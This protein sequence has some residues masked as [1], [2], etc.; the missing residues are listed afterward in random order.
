MHRMVNAEFVST[1][2][3]SQL[4]NGFIE[5][6][7]GN[8]YD[9]CIIICNYIPVKFAE[10]WTYSRP[11]PMERA[12]RETVTVTLYGQGLMDNVS[13]KCFNP[14]KMPSFYFSFC[15]SHLQPREGWL[16]E[17]SSCYFLCTTSSHISNYLLQAF[18]LNRTGKLEITEH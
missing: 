15:I 11:L 14:T 9:H 12:K 2:Y 18:Q 4:L 1:T 8:A 17:Y 5:C 7:F 10:D 13:Q 16:T 3:S 6:L